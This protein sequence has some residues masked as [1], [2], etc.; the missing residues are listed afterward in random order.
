MIG[1]SGLSNYYTFML[2]R[3]GRENTDSFWIEVFTDRD[4]V[5]RNFLQIQIPRYLQNKDCL[6]P[7]QSF[8]ENSGLSGLGSRLVTFVMH[9][10]CSDVINGKAAIGDRIPT[11]IKVADY[12]DARKVIDHL[13][14]E[15]KL[16]ASERSNIEPILREL[17]KS[18]RFASLR[19]EDI[20]TAQKEVIQSFISPYIES[21]MSESPDAKTAKMWICAAA[22]AL[23]ICV[24]KD[25]VKE[26]LSSF[27]F[28]ACQSGRGKSVDFYESLFAVSR[29]YASMG[30][31]ESVLE[32]SGESIPKASIIQEII[33]NLFNEREQQP[34]NQE[35][36][37]Q[38]EH[39]QAVDLLQNAMD[40]LEM[41]VPENAAQLQ[42][43]EGPEGDKPS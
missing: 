13:F 34:V 31:L 5:S 30:E 28:T 37:V 39:D 20:S 42:E 36:S 33:L 25:S 32:Q 9:K 10:E 12:V 41:Q 29:I 11:C 18:A 1:I 22:N 2:H 3:R 38:E 14:G 24:N 19:T 17:E 35:G 40:E 23:K 16:S 27:L 8:V 26:H 4:N 6:V 21:I 43:F 7:M 15:N